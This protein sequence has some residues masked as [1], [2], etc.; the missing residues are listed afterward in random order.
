MYLPLC[1]YHLRRITWMNK[2][3]KT[4]DWCGIKELTSPQ[5]PR[6]NQICCEIYLRIESWISHGINNAGK[7]AEAYCI[8]KMDVPTEHWATKK[9]WCITYLTVAR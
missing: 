9:W 5:C 3:G 6:Q 1:I 2:A 4:I 8:I 7:F